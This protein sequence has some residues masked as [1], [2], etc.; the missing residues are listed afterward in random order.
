[1][2]TTNDVLKKLADNKGSR[3]ASLVYTNSYGET[4]RYTILIG[5]SYL[6]AVKKSLAETL[7]QIK[8][9]PEGTIEYTAAIAVIES[10]QKTLNGTQDAY[11]KS[12]TYV[13]TDIN[14]V[15]CNTVDGSLKLHGLVVS[16]TVIKEG[17]P[18]KQVK[19]APLTIAKNKLKKE[20]PVS[21]LREFTL[22]EDVLSTAR[23]NGDT[24]ILD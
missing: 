2:H 19:S 3:F 8:T 24:L 20:H 14:G 5:F 10:Y 1:M 12:D 9:I 17:E 16:K 21:K 11:T 6:E 7:E 18:R 22:S 15:K 23:I 13:P 4:S